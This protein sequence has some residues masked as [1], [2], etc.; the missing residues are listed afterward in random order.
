M[1]FTV[2]QLAKLTGLTVR[3]L[4]HYDAIGLL[5]PSQRSDSGYRLYTQTDI[6]KLYRIQALQR[7]GLSLT[8]IETALAR[9]GA[10]LPDMIAQQL[11]ALDTQIEQATTL[12]SQLSHL[13]E[14]LARGDEPGTGEWLAAVELITQYDKYCSPEELNRLIEHNQDDTAAWQTLI[15]ELR[16]ATQ[17]KLAPH[18]PQAQSLVQRWGSLMLQRVGGD[19]NLLIKMKLAYA[20][21]SGMQSRMEMQGGITP[22]MMQYLALV[23][24]HAHLALWSRYLNA[25]QVKRLRLDESWQQ[26]L[27]KVV[28]ALRQ[29]MSDGLPATGETVRQS[30][31]EWDSLLDHFVDGDAAVRAKAVSALATDPDI[32]FNWILDAELQRFMAVGRVTKL[33]NAN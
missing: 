19:K 13:R 16:A 21:D 20:E 32:Q 27:L 2:G 22:E 33:A 17:N 9:A 4:H 28:G 11:A 23:A 6:V 18:S 31:G 24:T 15:S 12:R 8:E 14:V 10:T 1:S 26:R 7:F 5:T 29:A 3:A 30:L 25:E